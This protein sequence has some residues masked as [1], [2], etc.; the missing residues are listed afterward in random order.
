L[1]KA[2]HDTGAIEDCRSRSIQHTAVRCTELVP[3][4]TR[5]TDEHLK[6]VYL[7]IARRWSGLARSYEF[8]DPA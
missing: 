4:Q 3:T 8:A 6:V 2:G 5:I 1:A 7:R